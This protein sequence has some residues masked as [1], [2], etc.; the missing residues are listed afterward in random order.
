MW[1]SCSTFSAMK[2]GCSRMGRAK[3]APGSHLVVLLMTLLEITE[4][5]GQ[6]LTFHHAQTP[7]AGNEFELGKLGW[8]LVTSEEHVVVGAPMAADEGRVAVYDRSSFVVE[9]IPL[10]Q[11]LSDSLA[12]PGQRFGA[13]VACDAGTIAVSNCSA[14]ASGYCNDTA[15]W[16]YLFALEGGVWEPTIRIHRPAWATGGFGHALALRG[17]VLAVGA[18]RTS[19]PDPI[20]PVVYIYERTDGQWPLSP[21]DSLASGQSGD[22]G[23]GSAMAMDDEHLLVGALG[24]GEL[25][26]SAGA[27]Y[28]FRRAPDE[29]LFVRKLTASNGMANDRFGMAVTLDGDHCVVGAPFHAVNG[30]NTGAVYH[31]SRDKGFP[32]NWGETQ[33]IAPEVQRGGMGFGSSLALENDR[34]AIGSPNDTIVFPGVSGS[35]Q[36]FSMTD[37]DWSFQQYISPTEEGLVSVGGRC[38]R[39]LALIDGVLL[40]ATPWASINGLTTDPSGGVLV[41]TSAIGIAENDDAPLTLW[42]VPA[43]GHLWIRFPG[44]RTGPYRAVLHDALGRAVITSLA[45][46]QR[47]PFL[48]PVD[49][50]ASGPWSITFVD[51]RTGARVASGRFI[52]E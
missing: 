51:G 44:A 39:A 3:R 13:T 18:E 50:L 25:V 47:D 30:V 49:G 26:D 48:L 38:S 43:T 16:V 21:T 4:A 46:G 15:A 19:A 22:D 11:V 36:V 24:D 17:D 20:E 34:L 6:W 7:P 14:F 9:N 35:L 32:G 45:P 33:M 1:G 31:F 29:W 2:P 37:G 42:P 23:F 8:S 40:V 12:G 27:A 52:R 10:P 28:L 5:Q 41:Y